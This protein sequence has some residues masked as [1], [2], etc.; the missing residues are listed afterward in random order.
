M[1]GKRASEEEAGAH[2]TGG[3]A[4]KRPRPQRSRGNPKDLAHQLSSISTIPTS[5][6][7]TGGG[8]LFESIED[9]TISSFRDKEGWPFAAVEERNVGDENVRVVYED[10]GQMDER[11][12]LMSLL[13]TQVEED[14]QRQHQAQ[15]AGNGEAQAQ[16][17][18][19]AGS[20]APSVGT[21]RS[22]RVAGF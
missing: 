14:G 6:F 9:V 3:R 11:K 1:L 20:A 7:T 18:R 16:S 15:E 8:G 21:R 10:P 12:R 5:E 17:S 4:G 2:A 22:T 13:Q 19:R